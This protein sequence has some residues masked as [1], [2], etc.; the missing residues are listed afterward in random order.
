MCRR[1]CSGE[2]A[3]RRHHLHYIQTTI[4]IIFLLAVLPADAGQ[5]SGTITDSGNKPLSGVNIWTASGAYGTATDETGG[6]L[7]TDI[8]DGKYLFEF[9]RIGYRPVVR[10]IQISGVERL[11]LRLEATVIQLSD[12]TVT[13]TVATSANAP[14]TF[15]TLNE[16]ALA[17]TERHGDIPQLLNAIPGVYTMTD[18]GLGL[19]DSRLRIRGFDEK[20]LQ[21]LVNNIPINDPETKEVNW[22]YW[23]ML[24]GS[25]QAVQVQRGVGASLYGSGALGGLV[26]IITKDSPADGSL[27]ANLGV[28]QY[29]LRRIGVDYQSGI[30]ERKLAFTANLHYLE[31]Q[32]WRDNT[33]FRG[34]QYYLSARI[35][36]SA[37]HTLKLILHGSPMLRALGRSTAS[38]AAFADAD[39]F[40][41][42]SSIAGGSG[43]RNSYYQYAYGFGRTYNS[44]I[45]V[46]ETELTIAQCNRAVS[47]ADVFFM[48][49][50][51]DKA[52]ADQAGGWLITADRA[53]M[54][55]HYSHRPQLELHHGWRIKPGTKL[56]SSAFATIGVDWQ[57][58]VYPDWYIP[59]DSTGNISL[60]V[61]ED[62]TF[63]G[64]DQVFEYRDVHTFTQVGLLSALE[65]SLGRHEVSLGFES[66]FW[67]ARHGGMVFETFGKET[68]PVPVAS[69]NHNMTAGDLF[70]DFTTTK[71]QLTLFGHGLWLVGPFQV[72]TNL[73]YTAMRFGVVENVPSNKN[74]P[75]P[76]DPEAASH[77]D[78]I[79]SHSGTIDHDNDSTTAEILARYNL[80]DYDRSFSYLTPRVGISYTTGGLNL[81]AN[82]S[83]GVKE[84]EI[85]HF[86][87]FGAPRED[88]DLEQTTDGELG[89]RWRESAGAIDWNLELTAYLII[90]GGKLMEITIPE[91]A[92]QPG[93]DFAGN[94]YVPVG[95]ARY[96][97]IEAAAGLGWADG[98][99]LTLAAT[100]SDNTWGEPDY[101]EG[102]QKLYGNLAVPG[103]DYDDLDGDGQ[104]DEGISEAALHSNF[105]EKY[106]NRYDVGMPGLMVN[107]RLRKEW[108]NTAAG[109]GVRYLR[110]IYV[111]EDNSVILIGAGRDDIFGTDDDKYSATLPA[112]A[113]IDLYLQHHL[114]FGQRCLALS[115]QVNNLLDND[116]WQRGDDRGVL[117][118]APRTVLLSIGLE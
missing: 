8:P 27:I 44:N 70:Y 9:S 73:Q 35:L 84:P 91:K 55:S 71:P 93:Y 45:N 111:M 40:N 63:F 65:K 41:S 78:R 31:G 7:I 58:Y 17:A 88:I 10:R 100:V 115:L 64:G 77:G 53:S 69:I 81:Y 96:Q 80:W 42:G 18:G 101:S 107:C 32:G 61:I 6:F 54:N 118:G 85:R 30:T 66:R 47:L 36:P 60:T 75:Y 13:G 89:L 39:Q 25:I 34:F 24:A 16:T 51:L 29:G 114:K 19:G 5:I 62:G 56:T 74:Y 33:G 94:I 97:G 86:F 37:N 21:I 43:Q 92:N 72:M 67:R 1:H 116:W 83:R 22:A 26:N 106:G 76:I 20:R 109:L 102:A 12:V 2:L 23:G 108:P 14:V 52:P 50:S 105:V 11:E 87:G 90:F 95:D 3:W 28:G 4:L 79:W 103:V 15:S 117:P 48:N 38:V 59:R 104:W 82:L 57:D 98:W 68:V 49:A 113:L 46:P 99:R 110:D 112:V